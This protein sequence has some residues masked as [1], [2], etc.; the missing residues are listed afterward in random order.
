MLQVQLPKKEIVM[1]LSFRAA[2]HPTVPHIERVN[3]V[4][5]IER[6]N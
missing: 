4:P 1:P 3:T 6:V 5:H 2:V